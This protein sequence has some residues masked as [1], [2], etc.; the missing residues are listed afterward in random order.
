MPQKKSKKILIY[1]FLFL[2]IGT[3]NNKN[4]SNI[5]FLK[6]ENILVTG[7]DEKNNFKLINDLNFL[8]TNNL[9]LLKKDQIVEI[10]N[11]NSLVEKY[12]VYKKYPSTLAIKIDKTIFLAKVKKDG[13]SFILGSN[14]K[15]IKT[16]NLNHNLPSI[17]GN[18]KIQNF[19]ELKKAIDKTDLNYDK[20]QNLFFFKS[21]RWD[22]EMKDGTLIKLPKDRLK[23]TLEL[24]INFLNKNQKKPFYK[25]DLRQLNQ[26]IINE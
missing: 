10:I 3:L 23:K 8:R 1:F 5:Y 24:L 22:I 9:F 4:L 20:I 6:V 15:L 7:L 19:F 18:F 16:T 26:I 11:D 2:I 25:I 12:S 14:G 17:F 21:G 13:K